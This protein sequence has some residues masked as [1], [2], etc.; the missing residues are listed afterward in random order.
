MFIKDLRCITS[1]I[2][3]IVFRIS[4]VCSWIYFHYHESP[5]SDKQLYR[6]CDDHIILDPIWNSNQVYK[7]S[8]PT[9]RNKSRSIILK[10]HCLRS[11]MLL[12]FHHK[13]IG[14]TLHRI[15]AYRELLHHVL[16]I[17]D[18]DRRLVTSFIAYRHCKN[19]IVLH[20]VPK[21]SPIAN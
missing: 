8:R 21:S 3:H 6:Y 12:N 14:S 13:I 4:E 17:A 19:Q 16:K 1:L 11:D 10:G 18:R 15:S 9:N 20:R 2:C 5:I 7:I